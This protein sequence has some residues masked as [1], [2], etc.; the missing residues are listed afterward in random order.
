MNYSVIIPAY[1]AVKTLER[2][3]DSVL[4]QS[5]PPAEVWIIDDASTDGTTALAEKLGTI[6][7][8][9]VIHFEKNRGVSAARNA[10]WDAA[11][12]DWLAF[13]DADDEWHPQKM[14]VCRPFLEQTKILCH[15]FQY[16]SWQEKPLED[17][18]EHW[19][20]SF[21][22]ILLRN[23]TTTCSLVLAK[24][25]KLRYDESMR[26]AED[27]DLLLRLSSKYAILCIRPALARVHRQINSNGGLSG[28]L[29]AMRRGELFM[30]SKLPQHHFLWVL[31]VPILW[32]YS[33]LKHLRLI[34]KK[35]TN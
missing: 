21:S 33:L 15:Q 25:I 16:E 28:N 4:A 35:K 9:K 1:N 7:Q 30:Y 2:A 10:G 32:L 14:E 17:T 27:H 8:V 11:Q 18:T 26:Y 31:A 6:P 3:L 23:T 5:L 12:G 22:Q 34:L 29:W 13:L 20:L 24:E 19:K